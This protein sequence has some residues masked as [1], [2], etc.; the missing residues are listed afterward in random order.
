MRTVSD[1]PH[2]VREDEYVLIPISDGVRLAARIWRPVGSEEAPV[3]AVLEFIPYR[4]RDLTAQRDS[5][6]HPYMAGHGYACARVDLRGSGDS[7]GV[8]TDEYLERELLDA[9][10]VLAWLAEQPWCDGRTGMMGISW[11]GFN[12]LQVAAR[13]PES[14]RAIVTACSTDD[15]YSDDVHYMGGCLLGDNLSWASTMFAYNSCPPDPELVGERWRD[16]WHERLEHSGLWLDTWLRHQHRDAYWRHGSVAEDLDAIRVPVM[17]VSGWADGYSNSVFRLLE[18]LSVPRLGLLG[19]WSHKY[20]HLGQPGPAIGFL[21]EVVRWWDRWLKGVDNDVMDAPVLRAWMQ[22]SVAPSTSYEARPGRWVGEREWPSPEVALVP[23]D[24]GAGRVLAEG[25]PSGREDVLT[26]SSPLSTG[27]HAGKWCSYNAPPDLPYDQR[28]DDGG[29]IVFDSVPLPRRLE[30]LGSAVVELE[31]AVD[32]PDAMVA[33]RLCDVAPQGQATRVTYGLLNLTHADGHERPRKLVPGRRYRVSVPLNGVAQAFPAGHRV[34]VSV[35][36][37]YWPLVWPSPEPV[38][39]SVFQGEHTRVLLPVRPVEGGGDGRGVAAFGEPE[40]TAPIATSRIA[41]GEERWDLTQDLVRYGAAL[42]VVKDLGTVRFD[43]IG[44]EV[45]RRAE[46]RYSRVG[47]DHDSVRG[48]AVWTMGFARGD[49][50]VRTRTHTVLTSTATDF[51]LHATL[52]AYEGTRR[53]ATKI[54][55]S[56]IPRDHV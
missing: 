24:L 23:R 3:P 42:E 5:V 15:R 53:V 48:E 27:Q 35:S 17:A 1:L 32:R 18:G 39:L 38:T 4:R 49:W 33:V 31:L 19:P 28:E 13:R 55:T 52:D 26:L 40:G 25:E 11:G 45:T 20:P 41:P 21:Q 8:L 2:E 54:Y 46:E 16:M 6:H 50:S 34:R 37:S 47:D 36:T 56:V 29:S 7:E 22:E 43:D 9:E 12:A 51:H 14:L 44:L 10:E 30:I